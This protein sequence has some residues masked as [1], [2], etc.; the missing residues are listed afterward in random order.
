ML[1]NPSQALPGLVIL[2]TIP[3]EEGNQY[4]Y[5]VHTIYSEFNSAAWLVNL[6]VFKPEG[7]VTPVPATEGTAETKRSVDALGIP[8]DEMGYVAM[9]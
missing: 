9:L 8:R 6:G 4:P 5:R 2:E 1:T 3:A 7:P